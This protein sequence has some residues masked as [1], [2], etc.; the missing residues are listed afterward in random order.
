MQRRNETMSPEKVNACMQVF[1][2]NVPVDKALYLRDAL[3]QA[4]ESCYNAL[5]CIPL[6][7]TTT[8]LILSIFL[9]GLGADRFY[10]GD[11]GLGVAK[12]LFGWITFGIWPFIDIFLTY[13]KAKEKNLQKI[14][15]AAPPQRA[16]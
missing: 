8:T 9:G 14:L 13:K 12:L 3:A 7:S 1:Q 11:T 15:Q 5:T 10:I 6:K 16:Y 4:D 2:N